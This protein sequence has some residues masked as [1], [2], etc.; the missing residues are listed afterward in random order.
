VHRQPPHVAGLGKGSRGDV[1]PDF[2]PQHLLSVLRELHA[3]WQSNLGE[4][5]YAATSPRRAT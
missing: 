2:M 3:G 1:G 4:A 5:G